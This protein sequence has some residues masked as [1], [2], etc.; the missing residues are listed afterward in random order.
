MEPDG[1][2]GRTPPER[3]PLPPLP[4]GTWPDPPSRPW[5]L[6]AFALALALASLA[7]RWLVWGRL[8]QT[9]AL[10]IGLPALLAIALAL[11]PPAKSALG[12]AMKGTTL[13]LLLS[14]VLLGEGFICILMAAPLFYLV[15]FVIGWLFQNSRG[16]KRRPTLLALLIFLPQGL[17][18]THEQLSFA[19][20]ESVQVS[21][22]V[23]GT[24]H[25]VERALGAVPRFDRP[26]PFY[27]RLGFPRPERARGSGLRVGD[28]RVV[29]FGGGEGRPGELS[30]LV[31]EAAPGR[32]VFRASSDASHI[33]HW[34][35]WREAEV[36]WQALDA[37]HTRVTWTMRY[38]RRLDPAWYFGPWERYA[39][40]LAAGY[41]A[42]TLTTP[43]P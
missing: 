23:D 22:V 5:R 29:R 1:D 32:A 39:V 38:V 18:G 24:P 13:G 6:A 30:L 35:D 10:F 9:S 12:V 27:L 14:G 2:G 41:L 8:E 16:D 11:A 19:R 21:R 25:E 31:V 36:R 15:A 34:L 40:T 3:S 33:A 17:E 28:T 4:A 7:Y 26:L 43:R 42:D 20:D 37:G